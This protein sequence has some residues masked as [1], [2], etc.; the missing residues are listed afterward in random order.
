MLKSDF[1]LKKFGDNRK[2]TYICTRNTLKTFASKYSFLVG[3][4]L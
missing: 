4:V 2:K 1:A 3:Y